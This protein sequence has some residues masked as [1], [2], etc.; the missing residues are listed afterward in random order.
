MN[1]WTR[2]LR[3]SLLLPST[4]TAAGSVEEIFTCR[5]P[6]RFDQ[7]HFTARVTMALRTGLDD[8]PRR[9]T[10]AAQEIRGLAEKTTASCSPA[11][12]DGTTLDVNSALLGLPA[13][14]E[15]GVAWA[16][17]ELDVTE[18]DVSRARERELAEHQSAL[19]RA[20]YA[21]IRD[22]SSL[23]RSHVFTDGGQA[24]LWWLTRYPDQVERITS[25]GSALDEVVTAVSANTGFADNGTTVIGETVRLCAELLRGLDPDV[26]AQLGQRAVHEIDRVFRACERPDLSEHL[27]NLFPDP[28]SP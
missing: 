13:Y 1:S 5:L 20:E 6:S 7:L 8:R 9:T 18:E 3:H 4:V 16:R 19:L 24:R 11:D 28:D 14:S 23:L 25:V 27:N 2:R 12:P 21:A 10:L 26:R 22:R 17:C 15:N